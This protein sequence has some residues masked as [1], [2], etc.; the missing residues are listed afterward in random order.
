MGLPHKCVIV[1]T[2]KFNIEFKFW[3]I[4]WEHQCDLVHAEFCTGALPV[5][6]GLTQCNPTTIPKYY[7]IRHIRTIGL[8]TIFIVIW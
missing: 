5:Q 4:L 6:T 7:Y 3:F 8:A 1:G 2:L